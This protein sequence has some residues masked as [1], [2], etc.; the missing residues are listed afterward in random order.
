MKIYKPKFWDK[1]YHTFFSII[2]WPISFLYQILISIKETAASK[3]KFSIPVI[4][5]GNIYLGGTGKTPLSIKI[6]EIFK[7]E[8]RPVVLKK[9]YKNHQDEIE[10]IKKYCK[11]LVSDKRSDG[12][13]RAIE[14]NFD[15]VIMDDGFQDFEI[16]KN[17]NIIC[18]NNQQGIGNG[19]TIPSGPLREN[20]KSLKKCQIILINGK[21][22]LQFEEKLKIYN[23]KLEFFYFNYFIKNVNEFKNKKLIPFA[24]IGNPENFFQLLKDSHLNIVKEINFPD[25]YEY[26]QADLD[27]LVAMENKYKAKL[28]T[29]EKDYLRIS[30]FNR[31]RFEMLP[32]KVNIHEEEK[33]SQSIKKFIT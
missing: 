13:N 1:K 26:K 19:Y 5:V 18:F 16:V 30:P 23:N 2:L 9:N 24:G 20:L 28:V 12:I 31:R 10:L 27:N 11:I 15:L 22:N 29:T 33:F 6:W 21:K 32:I 17:L 8:K 4:C 25:H 3:K 7:D 14:K